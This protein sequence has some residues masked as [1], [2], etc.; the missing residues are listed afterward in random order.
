MYA[1]KASKIISHSARPHARDAMFI[2]HLVF[3]SVVVFV[4]LHILNAAFQGSGAPFSLAIHKRFVETSLAP[5]PHP[6]NV[7]QPFLL[8][9]SQSGCS[10]KSQ[11]LRECQHTIV[12]LVCYGNDEVDLLQKCLL[13]IVFNQSAFR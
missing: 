7:M 6:K 5:R 9:T 1:I 13:H 11:S 8:F 2:C 12:N 4:Y 3:V 10:W